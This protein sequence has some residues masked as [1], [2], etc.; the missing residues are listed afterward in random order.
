MAKA[1][2]TTAPLDGDG[3]APMFVPRWKE[4]GG[5]LGAVAIVAG[6]GG[7]GRIPVGDHD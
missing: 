2:G 7:G 1:L 6:D 5:V 3:A 4:C